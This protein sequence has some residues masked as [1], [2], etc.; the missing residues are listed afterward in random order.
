M[1]D[2]LNWR[3]DL[4][5]RQDPVNEV[6]A[7]VFSGLSYIRYADGAEWLTEGPIPLRHA[8]EELLSRVSKAVYDIYMED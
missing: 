6:D 7:L 5:F 4:T 1:F 2:Y 8:A 3:G